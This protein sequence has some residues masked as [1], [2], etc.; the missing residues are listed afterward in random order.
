MKKQRTTITTLSLLD[1]YPSDSFFPMPEV[2]NLFQSD[3][4]ELIRRMNRIRSNFERLDLEL[5]EL[6]AVVLDENYIQGLV[7]SQSDT[8]RKPR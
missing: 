3:D 7:N 4:P 6:E 8:I 5:S 1:S 2:P